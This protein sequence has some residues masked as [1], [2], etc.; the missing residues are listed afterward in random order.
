MRQ[1]II[2]GHELS[3]CCWRVSFAW[4]K[5]E[6]RLIGSF[7]ASQPVQADTVAMGH[8]GNER[9]GLALSS[10]QVRGNGK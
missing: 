2:L 10:N 7:S 4:C 3:T 5:Q 6:K 1:E 9:K 8:P